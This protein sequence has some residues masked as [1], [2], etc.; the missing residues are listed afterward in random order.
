MSGFRGFAERPHSDNL[1]PMLENKPKIIIIAGATAS[2]KTEIGI[3][4]AERFCGEIISADSVQIYRYMNIGSAKPTAEDRARAVHHM[5]DI[6]DPNENF[7]AGDYVREA[8]ECIKE[9]VGR[10]RLPIIVGGTGLYIRC[11]MGGMLNSAK[12]ETKLRAKLLNEEEKSKGALFKRL[13]ELDPETAHHIPAANI[14]RIVRALEVFES[15][16]RKMS[17]LQQEHAF[18]DRPYNYIFF[19]LSPSRSRLYEQIDQRV[20]NMIK[21]G[22]VEEVML[23]HKN[24]YSDDLKSMNSLGYRHVGLALAGAIDMDEAV[25]LIKRDTR[26]YAKRQLTW[27]RSEPDIVWC[28]PGE[29]KR[30]QLMI[31]DFLGN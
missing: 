17:V 9:I 31:D 15:T 27:F 7:S 26:R 21:S 14:Y 23:L 28:D 16:G 20:D 2:G 13:L 30:I 3:K 4:L 12:T 22:L 5:I 1:K 10:G 25:R 6:R 8:R 18:Q 24:G 19:G 29:T 11:L